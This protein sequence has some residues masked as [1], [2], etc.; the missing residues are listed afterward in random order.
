MKLTNR[1]IQRRIV[2]QEDALGLLADYIPQF[3][4]LLDDAWEYVERVYADDPSRRIVFNEI[5]K[6][7]MLH[8]GWCRSA[9]ARFD[10]DKRVR[11]IWRGRMLV[12][13]ID[14]RVA[15]RFKKLGTDLCARNIRTPSQ[16]RDYFQ[17]QMYL[18][19]LEPIGPTRLIF[20]YRANAV[21]TQIA[22]RYLTCPKSW[23]EN[24]WVEFIEQSKSDATQLLQPT[25]AADDL[26]S[27]ITVRAKS[28]RRKGAESA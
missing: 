7:G 11:V 19:G 23:D 9:A 14:N 24:H 3:N 26:R 16:E 15:V 17:G 6:A 8:D 13:L 2:T 1:T 25:V 22:G 20:G 27:K 28:A 21:G 5:T 18:D 12:L 10:G 4:E